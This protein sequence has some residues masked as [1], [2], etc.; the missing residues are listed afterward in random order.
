VRGIDGELAADTKAGYV[1]NGHVANLDPS[2]VSPQDL[3]GALVSGT[4]KSGEF[5]AWEFNAARFY[6]MSQPG[7]YKIQIRR[8]DPESPSISVKSNT[9]TVKVTQ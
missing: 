2:R 6:E 1:W 3:R 8:A 5:L 9:V 4:L 7:K